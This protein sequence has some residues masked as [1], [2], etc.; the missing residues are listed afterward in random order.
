MRALVI[1]NGPAAER[2]TAVLTEMGIQPTR[3]H[4]EPPGVALPD[5]VF[6]CAPIGSRASLAAKCIGLGVPAVFI[7]QP[8]GF[9]LTELDLL[10]HAAEHHT[11]MV[12]CNLRF[13]YKLP[14][15]HWSLLEIVAAKSV[16]VGLHGFSIV[17]NSTTK[18]EN[19]VL[20]LD[21][22]Y[23]VNGPIHSVQTICERARLDIAVEHTSLAWSHI[24]VD[25][26][27]RPLTSR[28]VVTAYDD[29]SAI[30]VPHHPASLAPAD[31]RIAHREEIAHFLSSAVTGTRPCSTLEDGLHVLEWSLA[32]ITAKTGGMIGRGFLS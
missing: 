27:L 24:E 11:V 32:A 6:I 4:L 25:W 17:P 13:A 2:R 3:S 21:L 1:G 15:L 7:E 10:R 14:R 30:R 18:L 31:D 29:G 12:G 26:S 28:T 20:E 8:L 22:A 19:T 9:K 16:P 23:A 5:A